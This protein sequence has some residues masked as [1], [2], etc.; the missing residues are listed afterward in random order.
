[1]TWDK[2]TEENFKRM[3]SKIPV[4]IRDIAKT[5]VSRKAESLSASQGRT[6][7]CEKDMV[8][9]FF[10]ETPF[11]FHGPMKNDMQ[12]FGINYIQYGH[13]K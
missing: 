11:G 10:S 2:T 4:F 8:D 1:M 13:E 9:A 3:L 5:K 12:E 6:E 7:V